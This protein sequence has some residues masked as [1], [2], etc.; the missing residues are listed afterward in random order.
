LITGDPGTFI[1]LVAS[2]FGPHDSLLDV[3]SGSAIVGLEHWKIPH[4]KIWSLDIFPPDKPWKNFKL[5]NAL[6][7]VALF[8]V[9]S[10]D[11]VLACELIE[12]L[13]KE[14]GH[15]LLYELEKVARRLVIGTT[16]NGYLVQDP[17]L[18]PDEPW[19][20]NPYQKHLCGWTAPELIK[21]GYSVVA[22]AAIPTDP[23]DIFP[24]GA[25]LIFWRQVY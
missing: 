15:Q 2:Y 25:S 8:G 22:N 24:K 1:P 16:P 7:A 14:D 18:S 20:K 12:H 3:G 6:E 4:E 13:K 10:F 5:G 23:R 19:A 17:E 9:Q 11:V 21:L